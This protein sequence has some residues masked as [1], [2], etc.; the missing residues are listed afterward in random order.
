[1]C[2][3]LS[4]RRGTGDLESGN[5]LTLEELRRRLDTA[6][7][8]DDHLES[9]LEACVPESCDWFLSS[10]DFQGLLDNQDPGVRVLHIKG[11][12]GAGKSVL[13]SFLIHRL[14]NSL[15]LP[16][17]FWFF[18]FDD[19]HKKSLRDCL[20]SLSFQIAGTIPGYA[21]RLASMVSILDTIKE[22]DPRTVWQKLFLNVLDK[23]QYS[24]EPIYWILD[25]LDESENAQT[26]MTLIGTLSHLS[27]PLRIVLTTR[28]HTIIKNMERLK[29]SLAPGAVSEELITAPEQ[30]VRLCILSGLQDTFWP[31]DLKAT[32]AETLLK[33]SQGNLL[34]LSLVIKNLPDCDT[35]EE[36][37]EIL[38]ETPVE[39]IEIY[40]RMEMSIE[41]GFKT[42]RSA[43]DVSLVKSI[44]TWMTVSEHPLSLAE[45]TEALRPEFSLLNLRNTIHRL[46][47]DFVTVDKSGEI[48]F[49][50][51]T[52]KEYLLRSAGTTFS[53]D[54]E[55]AHRLVLD[56]CLSILTDPGFRIRLRSE[57]W[58]GLLWYC[59]LNWWHHMA[60]GDVGVLTKKYQ[61]RITM[62]FKSNAVL[63]WIEAVAEAEQLEILSLTSKAL[64][65]YLKRSRQINMEEDLV[66]EPI[67]E[68]EFLSHWAIDL[69]RI[70]GRF[71]T[72]LI[73]YPS[74]ITSLVPLFSP[75]KSMISKQFLSITQET[76]RITG[77][78]NL[79]WED[80]LTKLLFDESEFPDG[81]TQ[82]LHDYFGVWTSKKRLHLYHSSTFQQ[83]WELWNDE[84]I[85]TSVFSFDGS[86][87][88]ICGH[89]KIIVLEI[90]TAEK[91]SIMTNPCGGRL[92]AVT[93]SRD[94]SKIIIFSRNG[95]IRYQFVSKPEDWQLVDWEPHARKVFGDSLHEATSAS[96]S[97]DGSK[98]VIYSFPITLSVWGT[99]SGCCLGYTTNKRLRRVDSLVWNPISGHVVGINEPHGIFKWHPQD[100]EPEL[101]LEDSARE[102]VCSPDGRLIAV[103]AAG[104][105]IRIRNFDSFAVLYTVTSAHRIRNIRFSADSRRIYGHDVYFCRVWEPPALSRIAEV[106]DGGSDVADSAHNMF[107]T[108]APKRRPEFVT[109]LCVDPTGLSFAYGTW[110]EKVDKITFGQLNPAEEKDI[111][112]DFIETGPPQSSS[113]VY[114]LEMSRDRNRLAFA[115]E[116]QVRVQEGHPDGAGRAW[117]QKLLDIKVSGTWQ[118]LFDMEGEHL[119]I[120]S[121]SAVQV[122]SLDTKPAPV[123]CAFLK[124]DGEDTYRRWIRCPWNPEYFLAITVCTVTWYR[125]TDLSIS[126]R[127]KVNLILPNP[128]DSAITTDPSL[129]TEIYDTYSNR[130][131][132][133]VERLF[134]TPDQTQ[135]LVNILPG[136]DPFLRLISDEPI[137][138][139]ML[140]TLDHDSRG[141]PNSSQEQE[142]V[143]QARL[144]PYS[145]LE[146][147]MI[148]LGFVVDDNTPGSQHRYSLA[149][150]D[151]DLWVRTW[152]V[153]RSGCTS[154]GP[155]SKTRVPARSKKHFFLPSDWANPNRI[156]MAKVSTNGVFLCP[157]DGEVGVVYNGL[158]EEWQETNAYL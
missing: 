39:L 24:G 63:A 133:C 148:P 157:R 11:P 55:V 88:M 45:M 112:L 136:R 85:E 29:R 26:F 93:F 37:H 66:L 109:G 139:L 142:H 22:V 94:G 137:L 113:S 67:Q 9:I 156:P 150:I 123:R 49:T 81:I 80:S 4:L 117:R 124:M 20:L 75:P 32:I 128:A 51:H 38:E 73:L 19:R 110:G 10:P 50:H 146:E 108:T 132:L 31:E 140:L 79:D 111:E 42:S 58:T 76:P 35:I 17:Q 68:R 120:E 118:L 12:P 71:G 23:I 72:H 147:V 127:H 96:F 107:L 65:G 46:C 101:E 7:R 30:S 119:L 54:P 14:E 155:N 61:Q 13:A 97:P 82:C 95:G 59:C 92:Q 43:Q 99:E 151:H 138:G 2:I 56:K 34:W 3:D 86:L 78:S 5:R 8:P 44:L 134:V 91:I 40:R 48:Y 125:V 87:L 141:S 126:K 62:F 115:S 145:I 104:Q 83:A 143:L 21:Q 144:L 84:Y 90:A 64:T 105:F 103:H 158:R 33:K 135:V 153:D 121:I 77:L 129:A 106:G 18:R 122:W 47:G 52:A 60:Q 100:P 102:V 130:S 131:D 28:P 149:Y 41:K 16:V 74:C 116:H 152:R 98:V 89:E 36:L 25:A 27:F 15:E 6:G 57:G 69:V 53:V 114:H 154:S 70:V 1:M